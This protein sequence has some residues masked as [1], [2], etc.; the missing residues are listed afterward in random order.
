MEEFRE[1]G[2]PHRLSC[3]RRRGARGEKQRDR[4]HARVARRLRGSG[5]EGRSIAATQEPCERQPCESEADNVREV[6]L[7]GERLLR[8]KVCHAHRLPCSLRHRGGTQRV[9][10]TRKLGHGRGSVNEKLSLLQHFPMHRHADRQCLTGVATCFGVRTSAG[11]ENLDIS[12]PAV[13]SGLGQLRHD[14]RRGQRR[15]SPRPGFLP[16]EMRR[17]A[18]LLESFRSS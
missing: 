16:A 4:R 7:R 10:G 9:K 1:P 12:Y 8:E 3:W 15:V 2:G 17:S 14:Q 13:I 5:E 18:R 6:V 11:V